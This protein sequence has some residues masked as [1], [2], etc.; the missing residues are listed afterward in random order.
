MWIISLIVHYILT[1][2]RRKFD[3]EDYE[4]DEEAG[5]EEEEE[6]AGSGNESFHEAFEN[7]ALEERD[8]LVA[9]A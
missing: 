6:E 4:S 7:L 5:E 8:I 9:A 1:S 3:F 2:L